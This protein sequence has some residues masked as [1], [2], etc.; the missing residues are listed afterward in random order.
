MEVAFGFQSNLFDFLACRGIKLGG[1][2]V[3][4]M[5]VCILKNMRCAFYGNHL[6]MFS[7]WT[8]SPLAPL[9][10]LINEALVARALHA[11]CR[12]RSECRLSR[13]IFHSH[14]TNAPGSRSQS[15][16]LE[17]AALPGRDRARI[18]NRLRD[19]AS[20]AIMIGPPTAR[21]IVGYRASSSILVRLAL[22]DPSH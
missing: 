10:A 3:F 4:K 13:A 15:R 22:S 18:A 21:A 16:M 11:A 8:F 9:W 6:A 19:R 12:A 17:L 20:R 1:R 14:R 2:N 5:Y 7:T